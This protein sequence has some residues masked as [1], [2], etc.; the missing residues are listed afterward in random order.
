MCW[1]SAARDSL[2]LGALL[3]IAGPL[4]AQSGGCMST[5]KLTPEI[6]TSL[7]EELAKAESE[8]AV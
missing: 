8:L 5:M 6:S 4:G 2:A 7:G 1:S 3:T